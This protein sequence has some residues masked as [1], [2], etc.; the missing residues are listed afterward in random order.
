MYTS[1]CNITYTSTYMYIL[2]YIVHACIQ[3]HV[4]TCI[5]VPIS[6]MFKVTYIKFSKTMSHIDTS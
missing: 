5:Q 2:N 4:H 3:I 1:T 6:K